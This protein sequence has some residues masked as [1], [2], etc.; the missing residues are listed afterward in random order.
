MQFHE[1]KMIYAWT[2]LLFFLACSD[3]K[4]IGI[5]YDFSFFFQEWKPNELSPELFKLWDLLKSRLEQSSQLHQHWLDWRIWCTSIGK[6][7]PVSCCTSGQ[8]FVYRSGNFATSF[9]KVLAK[10]NSWNQIK[11]FYFVKLYF[12]QFLTFSQFKKLI[13]KLQKMEFG[14]RE[15]D[16]L[17]D[18][19]SFFWP[20]LF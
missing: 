4:L 3:L 7:L 15:I 16:V 18:F 6:W 14:E 8:L 17:F 20:G 13:L 2:F 12:W 19:T 5:T 11:Q 9:K 10:K 1:K